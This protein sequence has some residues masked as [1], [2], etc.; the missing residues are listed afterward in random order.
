M[1]E[2]AGRTAV[3]VGTGVFLGIV[4]W[5]LLRFAVGPCPDP[6][7]YHANW[8]VVVNGEEVD[9]S[10]DRYMQSVDGCAAMGVAD[11]A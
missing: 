3:K 1:S 4:S 6:P 2:G 5:G 11:T 9:F 10:G 8:A 7:H